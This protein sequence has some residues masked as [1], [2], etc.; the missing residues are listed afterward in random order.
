[1]SIMS[2]GRDL[3]AL[4]FI[5][6]YLYSYKLFIKHYSTYPCGCVFSSAMIN[7]LALLYIFSCTD[8][9]YL[10]GGHD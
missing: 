6:I 9:H 10:M 3:T 2:I 5:D 7:I 8:N 4:N 1:M